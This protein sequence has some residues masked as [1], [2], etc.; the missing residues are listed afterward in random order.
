MS[1]DQIIRF[2]P[3]NSATAA[4]QEEHAA[5]LMD[6]KA[7]AEWVHWWCGARWFG[8]L[9]FPLW[10]FPKIV[11]FPPKSSIFNT[12]FHYFH[13][14][15]WDTPIFGNI[16]MKGIV[17]KGVSLLGGSSQSVSSWSTAHIPPWQNVCYTLVHRTSRQLKSDRFTWNMW[18]CTHLDNLIATDP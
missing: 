17:M 9:T 3:P 11:G 18:N 14:P 7:K 5:T 16:L 13:H 8:F 2:F 6:L 12:D 4:V 1:Y 15:F 10:M